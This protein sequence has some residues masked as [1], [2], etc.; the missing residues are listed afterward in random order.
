MVTG[1]LLRL[2]ITTVFMFHDDVQK[3][4]MNPPVVL[5]FV[6]WY[7]AHKE[8]V[9]GIFIR[10]H[11]ELLAADPCFKHIVVQ[12]SSIKFSVLRHLLTLLGFFTKRKI[13]D[14]EVIQLPVESVL[15]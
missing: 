6:T 11:I 9:D 14:I 4:K 8:D 13:G 7:P 15:Y 3:N 12:K 10:R 2:K 5:H 1:N